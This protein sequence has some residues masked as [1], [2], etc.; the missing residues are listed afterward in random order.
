MITRIKIDQSY[1]CINS[2]MNEVIK[3]QDLLFFLRKGHDNK[4]IKIIN[5]KQVKK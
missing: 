3:N 1:Y 2:G 5:Y 4:V